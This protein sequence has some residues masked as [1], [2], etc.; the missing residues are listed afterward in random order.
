MNKIQLELVEKTVVKDA[1][2]NVLKGQ[3]SYSVIK[4]F[5]ADYIMPISEQT[6][7]K[8]AGFVENSFYE[9]KTREKVITNSYIRYKGN[10]Y[11]VIQV[12][13]YPRLYSLSLE[14]M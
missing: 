2:G 4:T 9:T 7:S 13:E 10:V 12:K 3:T 14:L 11:H 8:E 5:Y 6:Q 1:K